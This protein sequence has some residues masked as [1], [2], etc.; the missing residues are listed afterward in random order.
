MTDHK[1][2]IHKTEVASP[3]EEDRFQRFSLI[4]WWDQKRIR[5]A[6]VLVI[7]AGQ[8]CFILNLT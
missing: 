6:K 8:G 1:L 2:H 7:G 5:D 3:L 4:G